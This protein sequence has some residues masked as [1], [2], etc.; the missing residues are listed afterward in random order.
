[1]ESLLLSKRLQRVKQSATLKMASATRELIQ[2]GHSVINFSIGEPHFLVAESIKQ[3]A[4]KAIKENKNRYT[5]V[6]GNLDLR[7]KIVRKLKKEND[8]DYKESMVS[9]ATGAKQ[10]LFNALMALLNEKDEVLIPSPYWTSYPEMVQLAGGTA[11]FVET[12][13]KEDFKLSPSALASALNQNTK[14]FLLN[15][16]CNPTGSVYSA[17][18]L[19]GLWEVLK[20]SKTFII[21]DEIYEHLIFPPHRFTSFASLSPEAFQ[22]TL[23]VNGFSKAFSMTGWRLGYAAG[24]EELMNAMNLIQGQSTSGPNSIAQS[25][26][27]AALDL[28]P[29]FFRKNQEKLLQLKTLMLEGLQDAPSLSWKEP[30]GTFYLFVNI[31]AYKERYT[32]QGR[33]IKNS[34]DLALYLLEEA[35]VATVAGSGF[36][37]DDYLRLS[38]AISEEQI[39]KGTQQLVKA[40]NQL[41]SK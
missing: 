28:G 26:A 35:F 25:A 16:P 21:S 8:L 33:V 7:K 4:I 27:E 9:V 36:G 19:K 11:R 13:E 20:H 3:A 40:L 23:T 34:E 39:K 29:E 38:F 31:A 10:S 14:V 15:N 12:H 6:P 30:A 41:L 18:E 1:M 2:K 5:P 37:Q 22:R 17:A 32:P 24:P